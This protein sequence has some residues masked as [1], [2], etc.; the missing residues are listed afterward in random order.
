MTS[1]T[2]KT[3]RGTYSNKTQGDRQPT[4][5]AKEKSQWERQLAEVTKER[6]LLERQ[7]AEFTKEKS[8]WERQL[9]EV[10]KERDLLERQFTKE[11]SQWERQLAEFTKEKSQWERQLAEVTKER[12]NALKEKEIAESKLQKVVLLVSKID[13][14]VGVQSRVR[15]PEPTMG[16]NIELVTQ[17]GRPA[18]KIRVQVAK[19]DQIDTDL[20]NDFISYL[21]SLNEIQV[22]EREGKKIL[23]TTGITERVEQFFP[24]EFNH[25]KAIPLVIQRGSEASPTIQDTW[26]NLCVVYVNFSNEF[27]FKD[28]DKFLRDLKE[29]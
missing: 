29:L 25:H 1:Y 16:K 21:K 5:F 11:K 27:S 9:A 2:N 26:G 18:Q 19:T 4:E 15:T 13:E 24:K 12:E 28:K 23:V 6:D 8:Q 17:S 22:A 10:T 20:Y 3:G 14:V 7:L